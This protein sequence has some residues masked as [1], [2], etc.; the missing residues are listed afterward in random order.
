[1]TLYSELEAKM[2][3]SFDS[4][5]SKSV[6][7]RPGARRE[8]NSSWVNFFRVQ[9]LLLSLLLLLALNS[10]FRHEGFLFLFWIGTIEQTCAALIFLSYHHFRSKGQ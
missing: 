8:S 5:V 3:R 9:P 6:R 2:W 4:L 1:M 10:L 7:K